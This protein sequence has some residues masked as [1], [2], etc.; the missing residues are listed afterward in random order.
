MHSI[1]KDQRVI[2]GGASRSL[3]LLVV[4]TVVLL[5]FTGFGQMPLYGRYYVNSVPGLGWTGDFYFTHLL[6][7]VGAMVFLGLLAYVLVRHA[8][9]WSNRFRLTT[10]GWLRVFLYAGVVA[11]GVVRVL[12]NR[13]EFFFDPLTVLVV[14]WAHVVLVMLLGLTAL[15][16]RL[17][18]KGAYLEPRQ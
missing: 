9:Q 12:K 15:A 8:V 6:H 13:P 1:V 16:A 10:S 17:M 18:R 4:A 14:D 11:T 3:R 2:Q 5:A 7:Y